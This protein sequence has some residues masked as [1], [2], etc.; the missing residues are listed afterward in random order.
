[1]ITVAIQESPW[2]RNHN[3][4]EDHGARLISDRLSFKFWTVSAALLQALLNYTVKKKNWKILK[5]GHS[6][7]VSFIL[8]TPCGEEI[9]LFKNLFK[10]YQ[11]KIG[12]QW[13]NQWNYVRQNERLSPKNLLTKWK[14][15]SFFRDFRHTW[16]WYLLS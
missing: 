8:I 16:F 5:A 4:L 3:Y 15:V 11:T 7:A 10:T 9:L 14:C 13:I 6:H 2:N 12:S 1:M